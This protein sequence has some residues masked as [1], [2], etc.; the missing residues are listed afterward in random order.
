MQL[1]S[2]HERRFGRENNYTLSKDKRVRTPLKA[3]FADLQN[4]KAS[5]RRPSSVR[6]GVLL[7]L[8]VFAGCVLA[9][10][11]YVP[12]PIIVAS[13][14]ILILAAVILGF[15]WQFSVIRAERADRKYR[16]EQSQTS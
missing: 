4:V 16:R 7:W 3:R 10:L 13:Y 15:R 12:T 14:S 6:H 11:K 2:P 8:I 1:A 5:I 9:P